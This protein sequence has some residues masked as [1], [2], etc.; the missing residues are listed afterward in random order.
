MYWID[1]RN[2]PLPILSG[3]KKAQSEQ[4]ELI[5]VSLGWQTQC[6]YPQLLQMSVQNPLLLHSVPIAMAKQKK[7]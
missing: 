5:V 4:A 6:W 3:L 1:R 2:M 7:S